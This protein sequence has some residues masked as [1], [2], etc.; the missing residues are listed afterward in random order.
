MILFISVDISTDGKYFVVSSAEYIYLSIYLFS[1]LPRLQRH[2]HGQR[3]EGDKM[4]VED[5]VVSQSRVGGDAV[6]PENQV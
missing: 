6:E 1:Y 5:S 2:I 4:E 3:M